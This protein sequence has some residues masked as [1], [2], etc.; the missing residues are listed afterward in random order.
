VIPD[1]LSAAG[2]AHEG[3][4]DLNPKPANGVIPDSGAG[5]PKQSR[6]RERQ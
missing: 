5:P 3:I 2:A 6:N 4:A 1:S